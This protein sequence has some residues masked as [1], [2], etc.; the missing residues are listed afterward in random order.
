MSAASKRDSMVGAIREAVRSLQRSINSAKLYSPTHP[1]AQEPL[2]QFV[3]QINQ[4]GQQH[5][6]IALD[7]EF[8]GLTWQ[9]NVITQES[10]DNKGLAHLLVK[11]GIHRLIFSA[12]LRFEEVYTLL[13]LLRTNYSESEETL[14]GMLWQAGLAHVSFEALKALGESEA[15]SAQ[16]GLAK[17]MA[18]VNAV[19]DDAIQRPASSR[20]NI[21]EV[22][23]AMTGM[24]S[25]DMDTDYEGTGDEELELMLNN[26]D[27]KD[28]PTPIERFWNEYFQASKEEDAVEIDK[29]C[30]EITTEGGTPLLMRLLSVLLMSGVTQY[31]GIQARLRDNMIFDVASKIFE[32]QDLEAT[33]L[34]LVEEQIIRQRIP[35]T[36]KDALKFLNNYCDTIV[37]P[38]RIADMLVNLNYADERNA[39]AAQELLSRM[40]EDGLLKLM[41][42]SASYDYAA[43][44]P[45][46]RAIRQATGQRP[47]TAVLMRG[48]DKAHDRQLIAMIRMIR[49]SG[50]KEDRYQEVRAEL[51][52]HPSF[53]VRCAALMWFSD[54]DVTQAE[55][56]L[57]MD[58]L[59][60]TRDDIRDAALEVLRI[61][62]PIRMRHALESCFEDRF[63]RLSTRQKTAICKAYACV[64]QETGLP[65]LA[66][67][68]KTRL[69]FFGEDPKAES[70]IEAA[71]YGLALIDTTPARQLLE[72][73]ARTIIPGFRKR[74]CQHVLA[75]QE[76]PS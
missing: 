28:Q 19:L 29:M 38:A 33:R 27:Q 56:P 48:V 59:I 4:I 20:R 40:P 6:S 42:W 3:Q 70:T 2:E 12:G 75:Q 57:F 60:D 53:S 21:K 26:I 64:T 71:A 8:E 30:E 61:V 37:P 34:M 1:R 68:F 35:S 15:I 58:A 74:I 17:E 39:R 44:L 72:S 22:A 25:E 18:A 45:L 76:E 24:V 49:S 69:P 73:Q 62:R 63:E 13:I 46:Y 47:I 14:A 66:D 54:H 55:V 31:Q 50:D 67:L 5:T 36:D 65:I 52:R 41:A 10:E 23:K 16:A 7:A 43:M 11:E 51:A 32:T 9:G